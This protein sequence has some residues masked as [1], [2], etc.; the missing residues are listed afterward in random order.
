MKNFDCSL[1]LKVLVM[2]G[3]CFG[4]RILVHKWDTGSCATGSFIDS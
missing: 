4:V 1:S 2:K 3:I